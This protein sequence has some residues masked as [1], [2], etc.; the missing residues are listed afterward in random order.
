MQTPHNITL[1]IMYSQDGIDNLKQLLAEMKD[2]MHLRSTFETCLVPDQKLI[3]ALEFSFDCKARE[4]V[5]GGCY[6]ARD[7]KSYKGLTI[8]MSP[9]E[10]PNQW[11]DSD[12]DTIVNY[13]HLLNQFGELR[14]KT[15]S[16]AMNRWSDR[17]GIT[18][19][20]D[21][22]YNY[23]DCGDTSHGMYALN[24]SYYQ[25]KDDTVIAFIEF[26][27]GGDVR[28]NYTDPY[29]FKFES[30]CELYSIINPT[31]YKD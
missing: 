3:K 12:G 16:E 27:C 15:T 28:G 19:V 24:F 29:I 5:S 4:G 22:S 23:E 18:P 20:I 30:I 11:T 9:A 14:G 8:C 21:N 6:G 10:L 13:W 25:R 31:V 1:K 17:F 7:G 2:T 26:H